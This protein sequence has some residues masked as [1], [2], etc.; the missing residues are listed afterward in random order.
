MIYKV[1]IVET[2]EKVVLVRAGSKDDAIARVYDRYRDCDI[3]LSADD[4]TDTNLYVVDLLKD[5][6]YDPEEVIDYDE[7]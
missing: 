6:D 4:Y 7:D 2:L 1:A 3:V 5:E